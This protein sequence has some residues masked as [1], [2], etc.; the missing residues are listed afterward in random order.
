MKIKN[1]RHSK[2]LRGASKLWGKD[3]QR[4]MVVEE[5]GELIVAIKHNARGRI[6][7]SDVEEELADVL[8]TV[9]QLLQ[10][11][12][13]FGRVN[14]IVKRKLNRLQ[15][16]VL[17]DKHHLEFWPEC[18]NSGLALDIERALV[19]GCPLCTLKNECVEACEAND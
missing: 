18:F 11:E 9:N 19:R 3:F 14:E 12:D 1:D 17:M 6:L 15:M 7:F 4:D 13:A 2:I 10:D 5:C 16:R 8:I